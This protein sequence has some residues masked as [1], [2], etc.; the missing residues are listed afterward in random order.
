LCA[1]RPQ[2]DERAVRLDINALGPYDDQPPS[3]AVQLLAPLDIARPLSVV[4]GMLATV[5]LNDQLQ[6]GIGQVE[7]FRP[8][9]HRVVLD[10]VD[11]GLGQPGKHHQHPKPGLHRGID[12]S[13]DEPG[14]PSGQSASLALPG[15]RRR[16]KSAGGRTPLADQ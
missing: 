16:D 15:R 6:I 2:S 8:P 11:H 13:S 9:A 14:R 5:V 3:I 1:S 12:T 7:A 10:V 4:V